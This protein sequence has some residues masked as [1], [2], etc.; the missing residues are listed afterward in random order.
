MANANAVDIFA[1]I[2]GN[3][4]GFV[5][6]W[7]FVFDSAV[8][9]SF[10]RLLL[11]EFLE[12]GFGVAPGIAFDDFVDFAKDV[13]LDEFFG[14]F[15][16]LVEINGADDG[17]ETVGHDDGVSALS[18][19]FFAVREADEWSVAEF[20]ACFADLFGANESGTPSGHDAFWF[21][22]IT[23]EKVGTDEF[24]NGVAEIF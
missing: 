4:E 6:I 20:N 9:W 5:V 10:A 11:S 12:V 7:A 3:S 15:V 22:I 1:D 21:V 13:F 19:H 8:G 24:E 23:E 16:A 2:D 18:A 14:F 17:F